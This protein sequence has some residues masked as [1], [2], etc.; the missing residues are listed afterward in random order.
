MCEDIPCA[1]VPSGA[2]DREIESIDDAR[3]GAL[4]SGDTTLQSGKGSMGGSEL[5]PARTPSSYL[6][7]GAQLEKSADA[8]SQ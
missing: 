4:R 5:V 1:K 7:V 8:R 2:L 6:F 3:D